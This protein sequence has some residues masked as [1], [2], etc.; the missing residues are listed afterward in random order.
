MDSRLKALA[1]AAVLLIATVVIILVVQGGGSSGSSDDG[2]LTDTSVKPKIEVPDSDPPT[3]LVSK[4]IAEGSGPAAK[5]GDMLTVQY[6][7]VDYKT[8]KEFDASWD[9]GQPFPFQLGGGQ[10]IK[11]WD[12]GIVGMKAGGRRELTIPPNLAYGAQGQPP[13]IEPN[14][15]LIFVIDLISIQPSTSG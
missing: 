10:V 2:G 5:A 3:K 15:T 4:D 13:S 12:Q 14:A 6:V 9:R 1:G 7:G 8:G 11:G